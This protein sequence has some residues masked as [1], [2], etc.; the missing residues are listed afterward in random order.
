MTTPEPQPTPQATPTPTPAPAPQPQP[1]PAPQPAPQRAPQPAA[2]PAAPGAASTD[3]CPDE[4]LARSIHDA[5]TLLDFTCRRGN[6]PA[7]ALSEVLIN[8]HHKLESGT[9]LTAQDESAFWNAL[10]QITDQVKP[11]TVESVQFTIRPTHNDEATAKRGFIARCFKPSGPAE[12]VLRRYLAM[13]VITLLVL[14]GLQ[15]QWAIGTFIYSD[16]FKVRNYLIKAERKLSAAQQESDN[17]K[18]TPAAQAAELRLTE[19][20]NLVE[21]DKSW[22]DVSY[23]R[24]WWWNRGAAR[25]IPPYDLVIQKDS[26]G[27]EKN[28]EG[29]SGITL[30]PI[31]KQRLEYTRT[32]LTLQVL[33]NYLLVALFALLGGLTQAL[34]S[35]SQLIQ[36]VSLTDNDLYRVRTRVILGVI[37]G[38]CMAWLYIISATSN[39]DVGSHAPLSAISFLGSFTPWAIAFISGYS[40]EIFFALLERV[41]NIITSK[42][43][44]LD[45]PASPPQKQKETDDTKELAAAKK[46]PPEPAPTPA[47]APAPAP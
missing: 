40:V 44:A 30:T 4:R 46:A 1:T 19:A 13:A 43:N 37:S 27:T 16:A 45:A 32:E 10:A 39:G 2:P 7:P 22:N 42:I 24:L 47:P 5:Y 35:L 34:R 18:D 8:S 25:H 20:K 3:K 41:I 36:N 33:S 12:H 15:M 23:V 38:V 6:A 17:V 14:L 21:M 26:G 9:P 31:G 29:A 28:V 11:V